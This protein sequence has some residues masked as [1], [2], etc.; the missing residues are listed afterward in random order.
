MTRA[1][2]L[3]PR[4]DG[5]VTLRLLAEHL[6]LSPASISLVLNQAPGAAAIP[7][8]TQ[9][10]I[11]EAARRFHYRPN[12]L[13]RSLRRQRSF[14]V[15]VLVPEISE[16]YS[17]LVLRGI[18]DR[19]LQEGY[20]YFVASHRHRADL[21]D[22]YPRLLLDRAVD[23]LICVDTPCGPPPAVPVVSVSGH[24]QVAGVT[25]IRLNHEHAAIAALQHLK[26]LG[27]RRLAVI[28]GQAFSSDSAIRW[29]TIRE[30]ARRLKLTIDP[31]A[32]GQ[33][34]G[35][36]SLVDLG[37]AVTRELLTRGARFTALFAFND[38]AAFG[39]INALR[40]ARLRVPDDVSVIGFDDIPAAAGHHPPLTTVR[41][42]LRQMGEVAA[43]ALVDRAEARQERRIRVI[44]VEPELV[45]RASTGP[46]RPARAG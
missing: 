45:I 40:D 43:Q 46:C 33:L 22:E 37:Y 42:P 18:E 29:R 8:V 1:R 21:L 24:S 26:A 10:R 19:L 5:P 17:T 35:D 4:S 36:S 6:Q 41:Q 9:A 14:T 11:R 16:G 2:R 44:R 38:L 31:R 13:A 30:A 28:R 25:N 3:P 32:V 34:A 15:G 20:L 23:G 27:H 12:T 7:P 39:A